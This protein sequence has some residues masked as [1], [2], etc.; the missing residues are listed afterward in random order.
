MFGACI[1]TGRLRCTRM[2]ISKATVQL[3]EHSLFAMHLME[4]LRSCVGG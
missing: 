3:L 2:A 1:K 4:A